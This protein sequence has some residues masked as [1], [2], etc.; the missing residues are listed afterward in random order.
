MIVPMIGA[1][2]GRGN[3]EHKLCLGYGGAPGAVERP[4]FHQKEKAVK[5]RLEGKNFAK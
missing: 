1:V 5:H 3:I 4:S 2:E